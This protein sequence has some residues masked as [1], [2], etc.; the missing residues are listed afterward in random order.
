MD[1]NHANELID[2]LREQ[3]KENP[4]ILGDLPVHILLCTQFDKLMQGVADAWTQEWKDETLF[5]GISKKITIQYFPGD[6]F[7]GFWEGIKL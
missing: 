6:H 5:K 1:I 3:L 4:S 2:I 7:E